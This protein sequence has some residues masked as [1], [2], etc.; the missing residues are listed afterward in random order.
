MKNI[1][2][3]TLKDIINGK[4]RIAAEEMRN[5][6]TAKQELVAITKSARQHRLHRG[7]WLIYYELYIKNS[8][9]V[10]RYLPNAINVANLTNLIYKFYFN[11]YPTTTPV[12]RILVCFTAVCF[13]ELAVGTNPIFPLVP[14]IADA[15]PSHTNIY[16]RCILI[17]C[18]GMTATLM[19]IITKAN[20]VQPPHIFPLV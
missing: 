1:I 5:R 8:T 9:R 16:S 7:N 18:R 12:Q 10:D 3:T 15:A 11:L 19:D 13:S 6:R 14:W 4:G 17:T 2:E 20:L